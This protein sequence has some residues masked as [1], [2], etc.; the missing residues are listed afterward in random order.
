[1]S[2]LKRTESTYKIY[3]NIKTG[4]CIGFLKNQWESPFNRSLR[5]FR[6]KL[7]NSS[8]K[9]NVFITLTYN[10]QH[11]ESATSDH[12][13]KLIN[14]LKQH[15]RNKTREYSKY[16]RWRHIA[17]YYERRNKWFAYAW[18]CETDSTGVRE[19]NPHFHIL[20]HTPFYIAREKI[21]KWW[22]KGFI[23]IRRVKDRKQIKKYIYKYM[24][25]DSRSHLWKDRLWSTSRNIKTPPKRWNYIGNLEQDQMERL[26]DISRDPLDIFIHRKVYRVLKFEAHLARS[27]F[28]ERDTRLI[29]QEQELDLLY[30]HPELFDPI[31]LNKRIAKLESTLQKWC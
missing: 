9:F 21:E 26:S 24:T 8:I 1:M 25:K 3:E 13:R 19:Y 12:V 23:T 15:N 7:L 11:V 4:K 5:K 30:S 20:I 29:T 18:R 27:G 31:N 6:T 2:I 14:T 22:S 10:N 28:Y 17:E 16:P